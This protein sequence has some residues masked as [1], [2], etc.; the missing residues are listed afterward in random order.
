MRPLGTSLPHP[1]RSRGSRKRLR[2]HCLWLICVERL[3]AVS[4]VFRRSVSPLKIA[5]FRRLAQ[6]VPFLSSN[7]RVSGPG[8]IEQQDIGL[9]Q[10]SDLLRSCLRNT[11]CQRARNP[12]R[13]R[14]RRCTISSSTD[15]L[16]EAR[17]PRRF[18]CIASGRLFS[19]VCGCRR[20]FA[21]PDAIDPTRV[22]LLRDK[23]EPEF[24]ADDT[25]FHLRRP[26]FWGLPFLVKINPRL[27]A[28]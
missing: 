17:P 21:V 7:R 2:C 19:P 25:E 11:P 10:A 23:V 27:S 20:S 4:G 28:L 12:L 18:F 26:Y 14:P 8:R 5:D 15:V 13:S 6:R 3:Q 1:Q 9:A 24:F 22:S 16:V